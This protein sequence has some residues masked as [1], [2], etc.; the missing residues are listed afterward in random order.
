ME[1]LEVTMDRVMIRCLDGVCHHSPD[2]M[3]CARDSQIGNLEIP[4][5]VVEGTF[6]V[7]RVVFLSYRE[8]LLDFDDVIINSHTDPWPAIRAMYPILPVGRSNV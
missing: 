5:P 3:R 1:P 8:G 2:D 6:A 7:D 4:S